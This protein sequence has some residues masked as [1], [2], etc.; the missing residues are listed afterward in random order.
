MAQ[1][2]LHVTVRISSFQ[3]VTTLT[4]DQKLRAY[5]EEKGI[6]FSK[7]VFMNHGVGCEFMVYSQTHYREI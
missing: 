2:Y 4:S 7:S 3:V 6:D 5:L 1:E